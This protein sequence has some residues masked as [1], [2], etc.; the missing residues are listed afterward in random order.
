[1]ERELTKE[2]D[3][4]GKN[5]TRYIKSKMKTRTGIGPLKTKKDNW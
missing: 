4:R 5:F 3:S 1:M 2:D